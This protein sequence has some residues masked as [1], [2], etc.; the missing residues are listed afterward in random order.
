MR[1]LE[2]RA[3]LYGAGGRSG[4][5]TEAEAR[6]DAEAAAAELEMQLMTEDWLQE[7]QVGSGRGDSDGPGLIDS[8]GPEISRLGRAGVR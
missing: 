5:R 8:D 1:D 6:R 3:T 7:E 2:S 4:K